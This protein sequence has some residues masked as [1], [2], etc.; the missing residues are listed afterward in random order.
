MKLFSESVDQKLLV[1]QTE[2]NNEPEYYLE[3]V[4]LQA[5]IKNRNGRIYPMEVMKPEVERYIR[6]YVDTHRAFGELQHPSCF[7]GSAQALTEFGWKYIKDCTPGELVYSLNLKTNHVELKPILKVVNEPYKGKMLHFKNRTIDTL[8]TTQHRFVVQTRK[9]LCLMDAQFIKDNFVGTQVR[10]YK[11]PR[12]ANTGLYRDNETITFPGIPDSSTE[13]YREPLTLNLYDFAGFFG[14]WLAEGYTAHSNKQN[15]GYTFAVSQRKTENFEK[16]R[17]MC[18][19]LY[20]LKFRETSTTIIVNGEERIRH[21]WT[22]N[23]ARLYN[24]LEPLGYCYDKYIPKQVLELLNE[25]QAAYL[26]E[27]YILGDGTNHSYNGNYSGSTAWSTSRQLIEDLSVVATIA[28]VGYR[29]S[30]K[31]YQKSSVSDEYF[32]EGYK[33]KTADLAPLWYI[34]IL[35]SSGVYLDHNH[36]TI[37]EVDYDDNVYCLT[38][39]DNETFFVKDNS[40]TFWTGNS[41]EINLDRVS[42]VIEKIWQDGDYF[43]ARAKILD[44]PCG[45]VVKA[46]IKEGCQLGVSSRALGSVTHKNGVDIVGKDFHLVTAADI[47]FEPSAQTAFPR[48]I[49]QEDVEWELDPITGE[50]TPHIQ[51]L[52][53]QQT[54]PIEDIKED[55]EQQCS[56]SETSIE[57]DEEKDEKDDKQI[58]EQLT[59]LQKQTFFDLMNKLI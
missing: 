35:N 58:E 7:S 14:F 38:V 32:I 29:I 43:K 52:E 55:K 41:P 6:E 4:F 17:D 8:V 9:E 42:H 50:Y 33:V 51:K 48:G 5:N 12:R 49:I 18:N 59:I 19:K 16:I 24:F 27:M 26:L 11:I 34:T 15:S 10:T 2:E 20:P 40:Y 21:Q 28:G 56:Q 45:R 54:K 37:D 57:K 31:P 3:G 47:V 53:E 46:M 23:D 30:D 44:T 39:A 25:E 1:E 36:M 13:K 22:C